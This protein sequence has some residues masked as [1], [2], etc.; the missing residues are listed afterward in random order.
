MDEIGC[1]S[2]N[3]ANFNQEYEVWNAY[4]D[5]GRMR[6]LD[7][8]D[9]K[10]KTQID[11]RQLHIKNENGTSE[12]NEFL[13]LFSC[14]F[15]CPFCENDSFEERADKDRYEFFLEYLDGFVL[16]RSWNS[17]DEILIFTDCDTE[18]EEFELLNEIQEYSGIS[19]VERV[20]TNQFLIGL[21]Y[22]CV[23]CESCD[24]EFSV[25]CECYTDFVRKSITLQ[26]KAKAP[27]FSA[28]WMSKFSESFD[29]SK[30]TLTLLE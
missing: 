4:G 1:E 12:K 13:N 24:F 30:G 8:S 16:S 5:I 9:L 15:S 19:F 20:D 29:S 3:E 23:K 21:S 26:F 22:L 11:L 7:T 18:K 2:E 14:P 27:P 6:E 28:E 25:D 17:K 10:R